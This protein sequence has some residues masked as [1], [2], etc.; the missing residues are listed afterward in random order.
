MSLKIVLLV[1]SLRNDRIHSE[2]QPRAQKLW[3]Q[4]GNV[5]RP[6]VTIPFPAANTK[7][8]KPLVYFDQSL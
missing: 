7:V 6:R 1:N 2:L 3:L 8:S 4:H 5:S